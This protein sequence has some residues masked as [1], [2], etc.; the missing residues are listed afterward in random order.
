[1]KTI[2]CAPPVKPITY[3]IVIESGLLQKQHW[4]DKISSLAHRFVILADERVAAQL[5]QTLLQQLKNSG[6]QTDIISFPPGESCK[7]RKTKE[8]IEDQLLQLKCGRDTAL[9][10]LGGGVTTDLV[11]F[12]ASTYNRGIPLIMIPTS[13]MAMVDACIGGKNGVDVP[14]GKNLI[15]SLYQPQCVFIDIDTLKTLPEEELRNGIVEMIK[16]GL[17]ADAAYF[18]FLQTHAKTFLARDAATL[19]EGIYTSCIIKK[20][21]VEDDEKENGKRRLLNCGHTIAHAVEH[22]THFEIAHGEAVGIG[23]II[24]AYISNKLGY[25]SDED[26]QAILGIFE[27]YGIPLKSLSHLDPLHILEATAFDKKS[28]QGKSR[29]VL[30]QKIGVPLPFDGAYCTTIDESLLLEALTWYAHAMCHH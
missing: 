1:M 13:L 20:T 16:H 18:T 19:E 14:Q 29:Y 10:A 7:S 23:I 15:G 5:G 9:I 4:I 25:L 6:L 8:M 27:S 30:L 24:E 11:G 21:I 26:F 28:L 22:L 12:V 2:T 3:P 17:I